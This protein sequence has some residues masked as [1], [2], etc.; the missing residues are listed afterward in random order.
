MSIY[1]SCTTYFKLLLKYCIFL[2]FFN[3]FVVLPNEDK[4]GRLWLILCGSKGQMGCTFKQKKKI[5]K[6][7]TKNILYKKKKPTKKLYWIFLSHL[8]MPSGFELCTIIKNVNKKVT[9]KR[10]SF[11]YAGL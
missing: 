11:Y 6:N 4:V 1:I 9:K 8:F 3:I 5:D 2:S 10:V 7:I